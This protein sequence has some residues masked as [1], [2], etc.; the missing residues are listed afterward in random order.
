MISTDD[1]AGSH[2]FG[3]A[4]GVV[5]PMQSIGTHASDYATGYVYSP[6]NNPGTVEKGV[7]FHLYQNRNTHPTVGELCTFGGYVVEEP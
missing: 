1:V 2:S 3:N 4:T 7:T 6:G 5:L